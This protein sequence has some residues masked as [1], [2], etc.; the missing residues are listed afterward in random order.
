MNSKVA[1]IQNRASGNWLGDVE[2][3]MKQFNDKFMENLTISLTQ[4]L[5]IDLLN[6]K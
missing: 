5:G 2:E 4:Q 3:K 6:T 1:E